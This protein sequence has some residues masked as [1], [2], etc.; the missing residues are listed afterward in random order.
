MI[1]LIKRVCKSCGD[2]KNEIG[3]SERSPNKCRDCV[4][5]YC[6]YTYKGL[7]ECP[8][9]KVLRDRF[10]FKKLYRNKPAYNQFCIHCISKGFEQKPQNSEGDQRK[11]NG[12]LETKPITEFFTYINNKDNKPYYRSYCKDCDRKYCKVQYKDYLYCRDCKN[13]KLRSDFTPGASKAKYVSVC[14][15]CGRKNDKEY[16]DSLPPEKRREA[17]KRYKATHEKYEKERLQKWIKE[18]KDKF[19]AISQ[20]RR[21]REKKLEDTLTGKEWADT[22]EY[23]NNTCSVCDSQKNIQLDH[24]IPISWGQIGNIKENVVPLCKFHNMSKKN[25]NPN[26]W[27]TVVDDLIEEKINKVYEYLADLNQFSVDEYKVFID[28][29]YEERERSTWK[30][31]KVKK[32]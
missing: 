30:K 1:N 10:D 28:L 6:Y 22:L 21:T 12:C 27:I 4:T 19:I 26:K 17:W 13:I 11:C 3:F 25:R 16:R 15:E 8:N 31:R 24:W 9:C 23:F 7:V 14:I 20:R 5:R 2:L 18:N 29:C 32:P